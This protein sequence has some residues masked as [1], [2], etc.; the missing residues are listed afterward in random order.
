MDLPLQHASADVLK[1]MR[2]PGQPRRPTTSCSRG[3]ATAFP[4][5][6]CVRPSSSAS[7]ARPRPTSPSSRRSSQDTG[8]DHV[9]VFTYSHEEGHARVRADRRRAGAREA[10]A[11]GRADGAAEAHRGR[12]PRRA[13]ARDGDRR[14]DRRPVARARA[15]PAGPDRGSGAR[16]RRGGLPDRLRPGAS[17]SPATSS[18]RGS[19]T[20]ATTTWSP[21][22][23]ACQ[24]AVELAGGFAEPPD[25]DA[26]RAPSSHFFDILFGASFE[27]KPEW[28]RAH[29]L[30]FRGVYGTD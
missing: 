22:R 30:Y 21:R 12:R 2:R 9:G 6:H 15:G 27:E 24:S 3:S 1:R 5:S 16:H 25:R 20:P 19:S 4:A 11:A 13:G 10:Q 8:F 18:V 23:S 28:A 17:T 14:D 29:F 26:R 7:R